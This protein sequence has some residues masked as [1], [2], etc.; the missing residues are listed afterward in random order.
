MLGLD[1]EK[2]ASAEKK[3]ETKNANSQKSFS[4]LEKGIFIKSSRNNQ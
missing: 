3:E 4:N 2:K 1:T